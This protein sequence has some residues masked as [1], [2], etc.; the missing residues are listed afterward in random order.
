VGKTI[1]KDYELQ[2]SAREEANIIQSWAEGSPLG[3]IPADR[4][5]CR[6]GTVRN[7]RVELSISAVAAFSHESQYAP[8]VFCLREGIHRRKRGDRRY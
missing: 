2:F 8:T 7:E 6:G 1:G 5:S 3:D 4:R